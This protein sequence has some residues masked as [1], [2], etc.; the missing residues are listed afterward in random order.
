MNIKQL[1]PHRSPMLLVDEIIEIDANGIIATKQIQKDEFF[2]QG[3]YPNFPLVPGVIL[4]ECLFQAGAAFLAHGL[5]TG[6]ESAGVPVVSRIYGAKFKKPVRPGDQ[7][8]LRCS[9][10]ERVRSTFF[11]TGSAMVKESKV[12][13]VDFA[14]TMVGGNNELSQS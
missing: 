6:K 4:C 7:L 8:L 14:V 3:H 9:L 13:S 2:L 12:A 10:K 5:L 11:L 1:I